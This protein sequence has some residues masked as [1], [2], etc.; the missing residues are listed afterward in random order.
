MIFYFTGTGNSLYAAKSI[1]SRQ[2]EKLV[3]IAAAA[4]SGKEVYEYDLLDDEVIGFVH[5]VHAWGPPPVVLDFI[6][7]LKLRNFRGNY[8]FAVATC[9]GSAGN[10]MKVMARS[11]QAQG[12]PLIGGFSVIMPNNYIMMGDVDS[13]QIR[14]EKLAAADETLQYIHAAVARKAQEWKVSRGRLP[15]LATGLIYPMFA[16]SNVNTAKFHVTDGC[17][18]CGICAK[19]CNGGNIRLRDGKP[20]WGANC[21]Q[22]SACLHYCPSRAVQYGNATE[23]KGRY[24]NPN[25][26][27]VEIS[28]GKVLP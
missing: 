6:R 22:C 28:K 1:A 19:V 12:L 9:G 2:G 18:G 8:V 14:Q 17:T 20:E 7:K 11:L 21:T 23:K 13:D 4:S 16:K 15:W 5:P 25:I 26:S 24:V 3:S 10:A 27:I